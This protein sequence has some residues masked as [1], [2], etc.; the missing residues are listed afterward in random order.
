MPFADAN[1]VRL[2]YEERG[3]G[4]E[5]LVFAHGLLLSTAAFERQIEALAPRFRCVAFDFRGHG[6]SEIAADGYDMDTITRDAEALL[7]QLQIRSCRFVGLSMGGIVALR[8][9]ARRPDLIRSLA[10]IGTTAEPESN[11]GRYRLMAFA[12]RWLGL[13]AVAPRVLPVMFGPAFLSDRSNRVEWIRRVRS[14]ARLGVVRAARAVIARD[15]I[16]DSISTLRVPTLI[17]VGEFDA[18]TAPELSRHIQ[19]R[20]PD[21]ELQVIPG[22]GHLCNIEAPEAVNAALARFFYS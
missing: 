13:W 7:E 8:L 5:T 3:A 19:A 10:L 9:A 20:I 21:S 15:S 1:G 6:R 17:L 22:A 4:P 18:A 14:N 12:A 16:L 2:Y 11:A